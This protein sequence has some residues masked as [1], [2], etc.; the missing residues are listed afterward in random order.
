M[1]GG[2]LDATTVMQCPHGG[3]VVVTPANTTVLMIGPA[4][5]PTDQFSVVGCPFTLPGP[6]P[7]PCIRVVWIGAGGPALTGGVPILD[8]SSTGLCLSPEGAPQGTV[9]I[10]GG[11]SSV[12]SA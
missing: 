7:S 10:Q 2:L 6:K 5:L 11:Q 12:S 9:V 4:L 1:P 8:R 3:V